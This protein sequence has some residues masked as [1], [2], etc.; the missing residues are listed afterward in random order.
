MMLEAIVIRLLW[1]LHA[2]RLKR[3]PGLC[4]P[5]CKGAHTYSWPCR[6]RAKSKYQLQLETYFQR[7]KVHDLNRP[8][9]HFYMDEVGNITQIIPQGR[10]SNRQFLGFE[11][12]DGL[13]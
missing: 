2:F 10:M 6:A 5:Q 3:T 11:G 13:D 7:P 1:G 12:F 9:A 4:P 8:Q